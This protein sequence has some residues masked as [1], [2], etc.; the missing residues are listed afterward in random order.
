MPQHLFDAPFLRCVAESSLVGGNA[1]EKRPALR[2]M[3]CE[4]DHGIFRPRHRPRVA[5]EGGILKFNHGI[6]LS[7]RGFRPPPPVKFVARRFQKDF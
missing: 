1:L 7:S 4:E 6:F 5:I 2:Y 3:L